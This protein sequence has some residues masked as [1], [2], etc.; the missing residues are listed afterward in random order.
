MV[1]NW[2][3]PGFEHEPWRPLRPVEQRM[4]DRLLEDP[5]PGRDALRAQLRQARVRTLDAEGS[6]AFQVRDGPPAQ[7]ESRTP[8]GLHWLDAEGTFLEIILHVR[9]G[10]LDEL[11]V[12][13]PRG[14][15]GLEWPDPGQGWLINLP[16]RDA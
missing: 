4:L 10:W 14:D 5:F 3:G 1:Q 13:W 15:T 6:L 2:Y 8:A 9:A 11:E 7:V 16:W 12:I